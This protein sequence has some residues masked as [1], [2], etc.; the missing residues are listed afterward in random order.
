VFFKPIDIDK[1]MDVHRSS[2][3]KLIFKLKL[4][5]FGQLT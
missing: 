2:G 3:C 4:A 5:S 1:W